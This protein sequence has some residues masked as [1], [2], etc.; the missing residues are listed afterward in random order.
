VEGVTLGVATF[1]GIVTIIVGIKIFF[2]DRAAYER[3]RARSVGPIRT[4]WGDMPLQ[5]GWDRDG[6]I[7]NVGM[8]YDAGKKKVVP[9]GRLSDEAIDSIH[10]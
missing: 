1:F 6:D 10:P 3:N 9:R 7:I 4:F 2:A 5:H 8:A